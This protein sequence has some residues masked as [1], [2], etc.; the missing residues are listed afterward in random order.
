MTGFDS[1]RTAALDKLE[2]E[3]VS[4][5]KALKLAVEALELSAVTVDSFGVQRKTQQAIAA[6]KEAL[7]QPAQKSLKEMTEADFDAAHDIGQPAQE[8]QPTKEDLRAIIERK[9]H[10]IELYRKEL[11]KLQTAA[12]QAQEPVAW[13]EMV[14]ANLVREGVNKHKARELAQHFYNPPQRPWVGLTD[15]ECR[16]IY[17]SAME[18]PVRD[19]VT[20]CQAIEAKLKEKNTP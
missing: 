12:Q 7:A 4:K 16:L 11:R 19:Q 14:V 5:D 3:H 10:T 6:I 9:I 1:K 2:Q 8:E 15:D 13:M 17:T 18:A 20:V